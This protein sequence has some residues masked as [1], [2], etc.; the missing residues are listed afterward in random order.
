[1]IEEIIAVK[2]STSFL[3]TVS[4][5]K[6]ILEVKNPL[7]TQ[8]LVN[9]CLTAFL[10]ADVLHIL[11]LANKNFEI[12]FYSLQEFQTVVS[13]DLWRWQI[14]HY[15]ILAIFDRRF[16]LSLNSQAIINSHFLGCARILLNSDP[17]CAFSP[18]PLVV[19]LD[20]L[21]G[22]LVVRSKRSSSR[23]KKWSLESL[24]LRFNHHV[25]PSP[26]TCEKKLF[27]NKSPLKRFIKG[28]SGH[29]GTYSS[30]SSG[31]VLKEDEGDD[32]WGSIR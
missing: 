13:K 29:Y 25:R 14:P 24:L 21:D 20:K 1:M 2:L 32:T 10:V 22:G 15:V 4:L 31:I 5:L 26:L 30:G 11:S 18:W 3:R 19:D 7:L 8:S 9:L 27:R 16:I 23:S 12:W 17:C 28:F 6:I